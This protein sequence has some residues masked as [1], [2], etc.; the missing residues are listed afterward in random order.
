M[1][2]A[3]FIATNPDVTG[4]GPNGVVPATSA[5][6]PMITALTGRRTYYVGKPNP[7]MMR[8]ALTTPKFPGFPTDPPRSSTP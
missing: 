1:N 5:V 2:G 8:T 6:A 3:R 7:V 4:P